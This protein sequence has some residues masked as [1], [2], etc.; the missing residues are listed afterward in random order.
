MKI[1]LIGYGKMGRDI[2]SLFFDKL[3]DAEFVVLD[4][5]GKE[6]NTASVI[7]T[8]DKSLRRKKISP[9][10][11]EKKMH[12]FIFTDEINDMSGCDIIIEA[13][14]EDIRAK[15]SVFSDLAKTVSSKCLLLTNT[16]SL[17]IPEIFSDITNKER[18]FGLHFFYPVKLTGFVELNILPETSAENIAIA[19]QLVVNGGK[20]PIIFS[21]EYH[22]Y[23]NQILSCMVAHA[24]YLRESLGVS[25]EEL[26][27]EFAEL[28]PVADPFEILNSVGLGLMG[29]DPDSFRIE[30]NKQLLSYSCKQMNKWLG[31]G[32]PKEPLGFIDFIRQHETASGRDCSSAKL[33]IAA[34]I[35][36]E[37]VNALEDSHENKPEVFIEAVQDT[38]GLAEVPAYYYRQFG[39]EAIFAELERLSSTSGFAS[40]S[41]ASKEIWDKYFVN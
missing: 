4:T 14:F 26:Q 41:H 18:C 7:K 20:K 13:I 37:L 17:S 29:G 27:H 12:S 2:F 3:S 10:Q 16:S 31:E 6:E 9:E 23:L 25:A 30:R 28:F 34:L 33:S 32:C 15:K 5:F 11:Y 38:L 19:E 39:P 35:L 1:G 40:Y 22:I 21:N 24:I 8:L 36:N